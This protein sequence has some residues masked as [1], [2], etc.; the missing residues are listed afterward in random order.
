[1]M[2][3]DIKKRKGC[4]TMNDYDFYEVI[5]TGGF[6]T[7]YKCLHKETKIKFAAKKINKFKR[8]CSEEI[9]IMLRFSQHPNIV[10]LH[11]MFETNDS[12]YL[13]LDLLEGGELLDRILKKKFFYEKEASEIIEVIAKTIEYLHSFKVVHRDLQVNKNFQNSQ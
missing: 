13:I 3:I 7:C 6:S 10:T 9:E 5:G 2:I 4:K 11:N 12:V 1:M 8:D